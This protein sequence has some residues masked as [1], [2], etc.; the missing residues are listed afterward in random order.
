MEIAMFSALNWPWNA[1]KL[2]KL[3]KFFYFWWSA[4]REKIRGN[5]YM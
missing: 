5:D 2:G 3:A 1:R 4:N